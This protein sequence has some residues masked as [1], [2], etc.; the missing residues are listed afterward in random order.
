[1]PDR[2]ASR[3]SDSID[4]NAPAT[5]EASPPSTAELEHVDPDLAVQSASASGSIHMP[6]GGDRGDPN[7]PNAQEVPAP[8]DNPLDSS[9]YEHTAAFDMAGD[10]SAPLSEPSAQ[11][12]G[13]S[14]FGAGGAFDCVA[15][16]GPRRGWTREAR[17]T[18]TGTAG[19]AEHQGQPPVGPGPLALCPPS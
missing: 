15:R 9:P 3:A 11:Q 13:Q 10:G 18:S 8:A 2:H 16:S 5:P 6:W 1:V 12:L 4:P 7:D 14:D 17:T 19:P